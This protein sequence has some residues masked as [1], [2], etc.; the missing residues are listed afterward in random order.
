MYGWQE[1]KRERFGNRLAAACDVP[2]LELDTI[3][4]RANG[5]FSS[6]LGSIPAA[7]CFRTARGLSADGI[8]NSDRSL[9]VLLRSHRTWLNLGYGADD[10][11]VIENSD[12][13]RICAV[14]GSLLPKAITAGIPCMA[15]VILAN[16]LHRGDAL[17]GREVC[18]GIF[19]LSDF[20]P[21]LLGGTFR[22]G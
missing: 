22:L 19:W 7:L 20:E 15:A 2:D 17:I 8:T 18:M 10:G 14:R 13:G 11:P 6:C 21:E 3:R 9:G 4:R 12:A 1:V 5:H 16:K